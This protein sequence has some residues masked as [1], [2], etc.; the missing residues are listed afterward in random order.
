M[1]ASLGFSTS[2]FSKGPGNLF[3][4]AGVPAADTPVTLSSGLPPAGTHFGHTTEGNDI[5]VG[6][7]QEEV[8]TDEF[9]SP[10]ETN[11]TA[12]NLTI[13]GTA[14]QI[15]SKARLEMLFPTAT[16]FDATTY[17]MFKW[18]GKTSLA[19]AAILAGLIL[20][21]PARA[22]SEYVYFILYDA[23]NQNESTFKVSGKS[24][25]TMSY[26]F[27]GRP[28]SGRAAGDQIGHLAIGK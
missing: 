7:E 9:N 15:E 4:A 18:G 5:T 19:S 12:E 21:W 2:Q 16:Y 27:K 22:A 25:G 1:P 23:V 8:N 20:V 3:G 28:L 6:F 24:Y 26:V 13:A 11:I 10:V 14:H 17:D